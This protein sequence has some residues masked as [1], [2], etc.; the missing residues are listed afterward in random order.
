MSQACTVEWTSPAQDDLSEIIDYIA[1]VNPKTALKIAKKIKDAVSKLASSPKLGRYVPELDLFGHRL[2]RE[3]IVKP[4]R[5]IYKS[6]GNIIYIM[7]VIDSRRNI[8]DLL[9]AKLLR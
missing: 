2:Y 3:V 8:E 1:A 9:L 7:V 6:E 5:I 4:W